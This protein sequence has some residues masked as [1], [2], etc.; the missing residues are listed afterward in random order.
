MGETL[1]GFGGDLFSS[2]SLLLLDTYIFIGA[3]LEG[4]AYMDFWSKKEKEERESTISHL[5][6]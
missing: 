4:V 6:Q 5:D 1:I 2:L 3:L